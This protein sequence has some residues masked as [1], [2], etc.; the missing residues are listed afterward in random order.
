MGSENT[1]ILEDAY[2]KWHDSKGR[3]VDHWMSIMTDD[4]DFRSLAQGCTGL[5]FT[6]NKTTKNDMGEYFKGLAETFE[7][8]HYTVDRFITEG[9]SV[10]VMGSTS[11]KHRNTGKVFDTPKVDVVTF[12]EGKICAF[13]E[14]YDTAMVQ[15]ATC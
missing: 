6:C 12:K 3:T 15:E 2:Q 9:D 14:Y 11:W 10:V 5:E 13:Y 7:M 8:V 1:K 4:V